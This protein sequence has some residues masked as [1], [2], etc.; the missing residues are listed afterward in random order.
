MTLGFLGRCSLLMSIGVRAG[1]D[2][3]WVRQGFGVGSLAVVVVAWCCG[4]AGVCPTSRGV[5]GGSESR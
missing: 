1:R 4:R 3:L 2:C 5:W